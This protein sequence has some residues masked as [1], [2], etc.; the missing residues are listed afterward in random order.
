MNYQGV[1]AEFESDLA[2]AYA[3]LRPTVPIYFDN[4]LNMFLVDRVHMSIFSLV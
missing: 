2:T 1:R 3:A 4:T